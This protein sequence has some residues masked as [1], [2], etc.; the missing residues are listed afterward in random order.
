MGEVVFSFIEVNVV[1]VFRK[2]KF[3]HGIRS[4]RPL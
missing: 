1:T 4:R 2:W 3:H